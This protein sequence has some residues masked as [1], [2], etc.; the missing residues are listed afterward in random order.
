MQYLM[1]EDEYKEYMTLKNANNPS[2]VLDRVIRDEQIVEG[3]LNNFSKTNNLGDKEQAF[4]DIG[5]E[6]FE[7]LKSRVI[8]I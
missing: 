5:W 7:I 3:I 6:V 4:Y 8:K 2:R 1:N